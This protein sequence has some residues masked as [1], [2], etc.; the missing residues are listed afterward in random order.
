MRQ[1][2]GSVVKRAVLS[3]L[4]AAIEQRARRT[5]QKW[6]QMRFRPRTVV[7]RYGEYEVTIELR[8]AKGASWYDYDRDFD[9]E[10]HILR[11]G[12]LRDGATVFDLGAHQGVVATVLSKS[13][14]PDGRVVALE[15][16]PGDAQAAE[17]NCELNGCSNLTVLNAAI[18]DVVGTIDFATKGVVSTGDR[19]EPTVTVPARTIDDLASEYGM[20]D[21]LFIDVDGFEGQALKGAERVLDS[22]PD[23]YVEVHGHLLGE[24]GYASDDIVRV[25]EDRGYR[26]FVSGE[27][28]PSRRRFQAWGSGVVDPGQAFHLLALGAEPA[29][30]EAGEWFAGGRPGGAADDGKGIGTC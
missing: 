14:A 4:P 26:L 6:R 21:V 10:V 29:G 3:V 18:S 11:A 15:A 22:R 2:T 23:C 30:A 8:D 19:R 12:R 20:P 25:F 7:R 1:N 16:N 27:M 28:T 13:V 5:V 17:R 9:P 24:Y